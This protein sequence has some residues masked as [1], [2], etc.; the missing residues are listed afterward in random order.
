M[1]L[2]PLVESLPSDDAKKT[3]M[4]DGVARIPDAFLAAPCMPEK[5][6]R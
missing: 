5:A 4:R 6:A 1:I 3:G 2:Q